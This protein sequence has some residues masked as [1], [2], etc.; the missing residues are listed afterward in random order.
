MEIASINVSAG[1]SRGSLTS[2]LRAYQRVSQLRRA[3]PCAISGANK[4]LRL[5]GGADRVHGPLR[6][7]VAVGAKTLHFSRTLEALRAQNRSINERQQSG[8]RHSEEER[9]TTTRQEAIEI[10][11][12]L[13]LPL[14]NFQRDRPSCPR[15]S[16]AP[17]KTVASHHEEA[18]RPCTRLDAD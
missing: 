14:V 12:Q 8:P 5:R 1:S 7:L 11:S 9:S 6:R 3:S 17:R 15:A 18:A 13:P 10:A 2:P 16:D 4:S